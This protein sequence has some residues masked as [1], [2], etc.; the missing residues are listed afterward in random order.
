MTVASCAPRKDTPSA[1]AGSGDS[2]VNRNSP[3][4]GPE[5]ARKALEDLRANPSKNVSHPDWL[6]PLINE[7]IRQVAPDEITIG[8]WHCDLRKKTFGVSVEFP[9]ARRHRLNFWTG[10][11]ERT[12][13][14]GW[15]AR[16]TEGGSAD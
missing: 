13:T 10:L 7:D 15:R 3:L 8:K 9:Q 1:D 4:L 2:K 11:F 14:G 12:P 16:I 6:P 5:D